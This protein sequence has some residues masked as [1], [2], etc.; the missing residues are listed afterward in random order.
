VRIVL[1]A[2]SAVAT[3]KGGS[4]CLG[5]VGAARRI[6]EALETRG[7]DAIF[8]WA[9]REELVLEDAASREAH[10]DASFASVTSAGLRFAAHWA[11]AGEPPTL[12]LFA[13]EANA[14]A[15][16]FASRWPMRGSVGEGVAVL[17]QLGA[18]RFEGRAWAFPPFRLE[19]VVILAAEEA[20]AA[21]PDLLLV[22]LLPWSHLS[23]TCLRASGWAA[24]AGPRA[25]RLPSGEPRAPCRPLVIYASPACRVRPESPLRF[26]DG[27]P[28]T[29]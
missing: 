26:P 6:D 7:I 17:R 24:T 4:V 11:W 21:H 8:E 10:T 1:D 25:I 22:L 28:Q 23:Y 13:T 15:A 12:D 27:P 19:R 20:L 9:P 16:A 18:R 29:H 3:A 14:V 5:T 2:Q